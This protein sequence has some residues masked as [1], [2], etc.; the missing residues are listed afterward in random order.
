VKRRHRKPEPPKRNAP[1]Q[2]NQGL[3]PLGVLEEFTQASLAKWRE[4]GRNLERFSQQLF[5]G[6][7][8]HRSQHSRELIDAIRTSTKPSCK[9]K[10]WVR[11]VD[12]Q[13]TNHPLSM[14]GSTKGDGGRFNIGAALNPATYTPF[15]A[16]YVAEDFPTAFRERFGVNQI[17]KSS[18]LT[19]NE[20]V[21]RRGSSFSQVALNVS[22]ESVVDVGDLS[23]LKSTADILAKIQL[24]SSVGNLARK[25]RL[26]TP[27]LIRT[28]A[29][30]QKQLL[31]AD[32][33][34]E[35]A[36]YDLP[37]NS[38]IFGRLCL[39][40]DVHAILYPSVR[41]S[42]VR[43]LALFPQNWH[44]STSLVE[45]IG[46]SPPEVGITRLDGEQ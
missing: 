6:L 25:L 10:G 35:P 27:G 5:F 26:Q 21:L 41:S 30:L 17:G 24:P 37:S 22:V 39:A 3:P 20:L 14:L 2:A 1:R 11:L 43:C 16:L 40:A 36:Q 31:S 45:L 32:W 4:A 13:Y 28:A 18:A 38:Q 42:D 8:A 7:E 12:Y 34:V 29:G 23:M 46:R 44:G 15:P 33:R 9:F 19:A